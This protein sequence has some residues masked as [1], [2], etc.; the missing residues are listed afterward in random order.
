MYHSFIFLLLT[1]LNCSIKDNHHVNYCQLTENIYKHSK[2]EQPSLNKILTYNKISKIND[3][4][5]TSYL[6]E[7]S[8][9]F[10]DYSFNNYFNNSSHEINIILECS[11][12]DFK[13]F[14]V[15]R[16]LEK[17]DFWEKYKSLY[18]NNDFIIYY[19]PIFNNDKTEFI[20]C[21]ER[22][23]FKLGSYTS[24]E[25]YV[26]ENGKSKLKKVLIKST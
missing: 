2:K 4:A 18:G 15:S 6:M 24:L 10:N 3:I 20:L 21:Y 12:I 7:N 8:G 16:E 13:M 1:F 5:I 14:E 25:V 23:I 26:F 11:T 17:N 19:E 22:Y 9:K